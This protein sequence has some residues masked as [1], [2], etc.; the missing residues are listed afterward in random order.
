MWYGSARSGQ[1]WFAVALIAIGAIFLLRNYA[2]LEF[3]NWWA[4]FI[5]IQASGTLAAAWTA[6]RSG[7]HPAAVTGPLIGGLMML[8]VA[9]I[10]LLE[11]EWGRI[12]PVFLILVGIG[13]LL[14]SLLGRRDRMPREEDFVSRG[15]MARVRSRQKASATK[16]RCRSRAPARP[17]SR[18]FAAS[19]A[20]HARFAHAA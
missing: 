16:T 19:S 6:W 9:A 18:S 11:L 3:G 1:L 20:W 14:P 4:L 5:L 7:M 15:L 13:A 17:E 2:G 12:W 8:T 10:F